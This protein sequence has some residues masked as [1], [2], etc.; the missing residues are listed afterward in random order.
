MSRTEM[1][2]KFCGMDLMAYWRPVQLNTDFEHA[3]P[4][5]PE[6]K[7]VYKHL[8]LCFDGLIWQ[9]INMVGDVRWSPIHI[10]HLQ[11]HRM[12]LHDVH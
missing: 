10:C 3:W 8:L 12:R 9:F 7:T 5:I 4:H 1:G 2:G 6:Q 11:I